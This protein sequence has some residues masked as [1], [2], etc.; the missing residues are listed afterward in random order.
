MIL[1]QKVRWELGRMQERQG[2]DSLGLTR[3]VSMLL[4]VS[5]PSDRRPLEAEGSCANIGSSPLAMPVDIFGF[6]RDQGKVSL[7]D[8]QVK[9]RQ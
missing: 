2:T 7:M 5:L 3:N 6:G 8:F 1:Q 9:N 4:I